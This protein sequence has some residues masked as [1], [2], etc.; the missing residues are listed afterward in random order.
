MD[1]PDFR[2]NPGVALAERAARARREFYRLLPHF[3][4]LPEW[5]NLTTDLTPAG[6]ADRA[7]RMW[8]V[9]TRT[10]QGFPSTTSEASVK[11][12]LVGLDF[13]QDAAL[14]IGGSPMRTAP[15]VE[16]I[17]GMILSALDEEDQELYRHPRAVAEYLVRLAGET[18][19][20]P[21]PEVES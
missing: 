10:G 11:A 16:L 2:E 14:L 1:I 17:D 9:I 7:A 4:R 5:E 13:I 19:A 12:A 8:A 20:F 21:S 18:G 3:V 6:Y 15:G